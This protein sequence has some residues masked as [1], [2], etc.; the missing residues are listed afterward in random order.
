MN[1]HLRNG[2]K[3]DPSSFLVPGWEGESLASKSSLYLK[4][5][6]SNLLE[7]SIRQFTGVLNFNE[8]LKKNIHREYISFTQAYQLKPEEL[9]KG[10]VF[11]KHVYDNASPSRKELD[12]F[13]RKFCLKAVNLYLY[14]VKFVA[15]LASENL[16]S[17]SSHNLLNPHSF[18][19]QTFSFGG[20][21]D[22][23]CEALQRNTYSW[24]HPS[25]DSA[26]LI[27]QDT[28]SFS[29]IS[30]AELMLLSRLNGEEADSLVAHKHYSHTLSHKLLGLLLNNLMVFIPIW[31]E[32][33]QFSY[34]LP[35][36]NGYPEILSTKFEGDFVSSLSYSHWLAQEF[37]Q[38]MLWSEILCPGFVD[39][40]FETGSFLRYCH[41]LQFLIF[42]ASYS[43]RYQSH[44]LNFIARVMREKYEKSEEILSSQPSLFSRY[45]LKRKLFYDRIVL[46]ISDL[47]DKNPHHYLLSRIQYQSKL[48][49][50]NGYLIVM[51]NQNLFIASQSSK[52]HQLMEDFKLEFF[53]KMEELHGK[54]EIPHYI[55]VFSKKTSNL[56]KVSAQG[57]IAC[58]KNLNFHTLQW[59]GNLAPFEK[60]KCFLNELETFLQEKNPVTTPLYQKDL[61][62]GLCFKFQQ[63]AILEG[64]LLL[65]SSDKKSVSITH[66]NF[67]KNLIQTCSPLD[68]FFAVEQLGV[69]KSS[70]LKQAFAVGLLGV[71][72]S[73]EER[74]SHILIVD[75]SHDFQISLE[76]VSSKSYRAKLKKYG[77]AFYQYFGLV[78]KIA[79]LDINLFREFFLTDLGRQVIQ[80]SLQ[81]GMK[82][83][84]AKLKSLLIP[85]IF[86]HPLEI[87]S[88]IRD[89]QHFLYSTSEQI[90]RF[91]PRD[92][93]QK[94]HRCK[95]MF[96]K[97]ETLSPRCQ[98]HLLAHFKHQI[99]GAMSVS[100]LSESNKVDFNNEIIKKPL[101]NLRY[102]PIYPKNKDIYIEFLIGNVEELQ[103]TCE[104][105]VLEIDDDRASLSLMTTQGEAKVRLHS[106][107]DYLEFVHYVLSSVRGQNF[108]F[109]IKNIRLPRLDD[110]KEVLRNYE[111]MDDCLRDVHGDVQELLGQIITRQIIAL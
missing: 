7:D 92:I 70:E 34:P 72:V 35:L 60:F 103:C 73:K 82:K 62:E 10:H 61:Q 8:S 44:P 31:K 26:Q 5:I 106:E 67:F 25:G 76:V 45:N 27:V 78:P 36:K 41:E 48:L 93:L 84:K 9:E 85:N 80:I 86:A 3:F 14:K 39:E 2:D 111:M 1:L 83:S 12:L 68:Q 110:F 89:K 11:W 65:S 47:P 28:Q 105:F 87:S 13:I 17:V 104:E 74:F 50:S 29:Q 77:R 95:E 109:L 49:T 99:V 30:T 32:R 22:L 64:G 16:V 21:R 97:Q 19:T 59:S 57:D 23:M 55:Y 6:Q 58:R 101:L 71:T 91:H 33:E 15:T 42:L 79:G 40:H 107:P 54:G 102:F 43:K 100:I 56:E 98:M 63:D 66:P 37:N 20:P 52:I 38:K 24:Y 96:I 90:R 51:S 69:P 94:W 4:R 18:F 75:Y 53:L 108:A 88:V 46:N 81:G